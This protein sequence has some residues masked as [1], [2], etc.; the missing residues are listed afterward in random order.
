VACAGA[1]ADAFGQEILM[2]P[3]TVYVNGMRSVP[4]V[5]VVILWFFL[6]VPASFLQFD[7]GGQQ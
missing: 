6:L 3:A 2:V 5:I 4:L 1:G 7:P